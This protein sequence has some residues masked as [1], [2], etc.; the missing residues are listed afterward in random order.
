MFYKQNCTCQ[1]YNLLTIKALLVTYVWFLSTWKQCAPL[2]CIDV[3]SQ[4]LS[5]SYFVLCLITMKDNS[6]LDT[7]LSVFLHYV[8]WKT[9]ATHWNSTYHKTSNNI[10]STKWPWISLHQ[11]VYINASFLKLPTYT[12]LPVQWNCEKQ[13]V[14]LRLIAYF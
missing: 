9:H 11:F 1:W 6:L 8:R 3:Q 12:Y 10:I 4:K 2:Y 14:I 5:C 13:I 7:A